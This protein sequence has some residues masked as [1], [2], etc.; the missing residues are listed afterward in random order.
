[1][2]SFMFLRIIKIFREYFTKKHSCNCEFCLIVGKFVNNLVVDRFDDLNE[3]WEVY[4]K[5][6]I[7]R[8]HK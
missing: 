7:K 8:V 1:M 5:I 4:K 3:I 2:K 6:P